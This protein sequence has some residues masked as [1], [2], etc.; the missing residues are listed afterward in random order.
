MYLLLMSLMAN[1]APPTRL[2]TSVDLS[3]GSVARLSLSSDRNILMGVR[4][5]EAFVYDLESWTLHNLPDADCS[6]ASAAARTL[7][8]GTYA[9][10]V[11]CDD[12]TVSLWDYDGQSPTI[13]TTTGSDT[14]AE[15]T[16]SFFNLSDASISREASVDGLFLLESDGSLLAVACDSEKGNFATALDPLTGVSLVT[17]PTALLTGNCSDAVAVNDTTAAVHR[18]SGE[19]SQLSLN[20]GLLSVTEL[21]SAF[22]T[23][24]GIRPSGRDLSVYGNTYYIPDVDTDTLYGLGGT[25]V[26]APILSV[27]S[28]GAAAFDDAEGWTLIGRPNGVS[29]FDALTGALEQASD[30][31]IVMD[32]P[33][34]IVTDDQGYAFVGT[35]SGTLGVLTANPW[36]NSA[37]LEPSSGQDGTTVV[38]SYDSDTTGALSVRVGG[39]RAGNDGTE[40]YA[41][42]VDQTGFEQQVSFDIGDAFVEGVNDLFVVVT[43]EAG[44]RGTRRVQFELA[45]PP[46]GVVLAEADVGFGDGR[47]LVDLGGL[48]TTDVASFE[49]YFSDA[50]FSG[51]DYE[52]GGPE[53][54]EEV[55]DESVSSPM[56][57]SNEPDIFGEL[58]VGIEPVINGKTYYVGVRT[59]D[60]T[61]LESV[62]SNV[63][64]VIPRATFLAA[65]A[66]DEQGGPPDACSGCSG[67]STPGSWL[68]LSLLAMLG[69]RRKRVGTLG[70]AF[71]AAPLLWSN[72][73]MADDPTGRFQP[74]LTPAWGNVEVS[75]G[76]LA[77][78]DATLDQVYDLNG[79]VIRL[80]GGPQFFRI[81]EV[82]FG[83]GFLWK[84]GFAVD[85]SDV[86]SADAGRMV[87]VP[88]NLDFTLRLH[89]MDE[90]PI[91][92]FGSVGGDYIFWRETALA[93]DGTPNPLQRTIGSKAGWHWAAGGQ[94]LLD[95]L[96]P[97]RASRLEASSGINDTWLT[98]S[99][100]RQYVGSDTGL[101]FGGWELSG[102]LKIDF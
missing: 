46:D 43:D 74:D 11:G 40:V 73:A 59:V 24:I 89:L 28:P 14:G 42:T 63:V 67:V 52:T 58:T 39:T 93:A 34:D 68:G 95:L 25:G 49:V 91:V 15:T 77:F 94:I 7:D 17:A 82:D 37:S 12:A 41:G 66:A 18:G 83:V 2:A 70:L 22:G 9:L 65:G 79:N 97:G 53:Y 78:D 64:E 80:Q 10:F 60:A 5:D 13:R 87:W 31:N 26:W 23:P 90:Q 19:I 98:V 69:I 101:D 92:P 1:A 55:G 71:I 50:P 75:Y 86:S 33:Y 62:M 84:K 3:T 76:K 51:A 45:N 44:R 36:V 81:A 4:N 30:R 35:T 57:V 54:T 96:A 99:Y 85:A 47:I 16:S 72:P 61:G 48:A 56:N 21:A 88:L 8:D 6:A 38:V 32:E 102:G 29:V 20:N 27:E 100:R